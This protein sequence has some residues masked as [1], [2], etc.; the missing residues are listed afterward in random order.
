MILIQGQ[1]DMIIPAVKG[2]FYLDGFS[3]KLDF[4]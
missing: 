3:D 4:V 1:G 2:Q